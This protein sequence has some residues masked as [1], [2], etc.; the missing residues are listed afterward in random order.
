MECVCVLFTYNRHR[1]EQ[2]IVIHRHKTARSASFRF[3]WESIGAEGMLQEFTVV[4]PRLNHMLSHGLY[5]GL[6]G[7]L[8]RIY[9]RRRLRRRR[10][11]LS[12]NL[13]RL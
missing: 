12:E 4:E 5:I 1:D 13:W 2:Y 10:R 8:R 6:R 9:E 11:R 3:R 7:R